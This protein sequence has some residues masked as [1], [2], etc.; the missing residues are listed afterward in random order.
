MSM[1]I[2][3][4]EAKLADGKTY[5]IFSED[6]KK[7]LIQNTGQFLICDEADWDKAKIC[8]WYMKDKKVVNGIGT[9]FEKYVGI[10]GKKTENAS[11]LDFRRKHYA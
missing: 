10:N 5:N 2:K 7:L 3:L 1:K 6:F 9:T 8:K 11:T 4:G